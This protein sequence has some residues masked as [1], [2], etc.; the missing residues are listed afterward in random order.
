MKIRTCLLEADDDN[1]INLDLHADT[2][3]KFPDRIYLKRWKDPDSA[4]ALHIKVKG[5]SELGNVKCYSIEFS[6]K[7]CS[8]PAD[9]R[10][11]AEKRSDHFGQE[12]TMEP[13][14][15]CLGVSV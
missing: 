14:T 10:W 3:F 6:G 8:D 15:L 4:D 13:V 5:D 9:E 12:P 7:L 1:A 11:T 2:I